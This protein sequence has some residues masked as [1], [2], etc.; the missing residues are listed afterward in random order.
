MSADAGHTSIGPP[1]LGAPVVGSLGQRTPSAG[2][3]VSTLAFDT[4][5]V[6]PCDAFPTAQLL[7][8]LGLYP[9]EVTRTRLLQT[10]H[11]HAVYRLEG[12]ASS[13]IL[14]WSPELPSAVEVRNYALLQAHGIPTLAVH[15]R[16]ACALRLEDVTTSRTWRLADEANAKRA[17]T[18][19]AVAAWY[20]RLHEG[21][22]EALQDPLE[23]V[24]HLAW[25]MEVLDARTVSDLAARLDRADDPAWALAAGCIEALK[26]GMRALPATLLHNDFH[27]TNLALA[28]QH[29]VGPGAI[30]FDYH[31]LGIGPAASDY[32]NV[33]SALEGRA[34]TAFQEAYGP[35]DHRAALLDAPL[36]LL[37]ALHLAVRQPRWPAWGERC[38]R[39]VRD[40]GFARSLQS[41]LAVL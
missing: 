18:G 7:G 21:G 16:T 39:D 34:R 2:L 10:R 29:E 15:G 36:A 20:R 17:A 40:G 25:E 38:L 9:G 1:Q 26:A 13:F 22:Q 33:L 37:Y 5:R 27:W 14:K 32:R 24:A 41:A 19:V 3:D 30:V 12:G 4:R 23:P 35:I 31:L 28:R 11:G 8:D 6:I